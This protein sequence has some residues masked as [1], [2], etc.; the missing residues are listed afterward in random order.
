[1]LESFELHHELLDPRHDALA[2]RADFAACLN[3]RGVYNTIHF[4]LRLSPR[5]HK[6]IEAIPAGFH[7]PKD[8]DSETIE[9]F[10]TYIHE[11]VH[12]WQHVGST[13]GLIYSLSYPTATHSNAESLKS[14]LQLVGPKK[15]VLLWAEREQRAGRSAAD[16]GL[17]AA[18][19]VVNNA[20]DLEFY[21]AFTANPMIAGELVKSPYFES[22]GHS[23][24]IAYSHAVNVIA[25]TVDPDFNHIPGGEGWDRAFEGLAAEQHE[26][27]YYGSPVRVGPVGIRAIGAVYSA[28]VPYSCDQ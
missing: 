10:S 27:Y 14:V 19:T 8:L 22:I 9:A 23:Y 6:L 24:R 2:A 21:K 20:I 5:I 3:A 4:V 26:G 7:S 28:A 1:L 11:T 12:W 16:P 15:S 25:G 17:Q 13:A 18:N